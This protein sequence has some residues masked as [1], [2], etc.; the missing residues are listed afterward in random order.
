[1]SYEIFVQSL[2]FSA[3]QSNTVTRPETMTGKMDK[4]LS[5]SRRGALTSRLKSLVDSTSK[6]QVS[7]GQM[8][9]L[10]KCRYECVLQHFYLC[11]FLA[12]VEPFQHHQSPWS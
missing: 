5:Q 4:L 3:I 9:E 6:R 11:R 7:P 1:M 12:W 2:T 8:S 10:I